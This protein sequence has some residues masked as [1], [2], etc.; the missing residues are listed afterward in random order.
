M[1]QN[2]KDQPL[3]TAEHIIESG[4][5]MT[6]DTV[7]INQRVYKSCIYPVACIIIVM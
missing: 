3:L 1:I 7:P 2:I 4:A 5:F 6:M